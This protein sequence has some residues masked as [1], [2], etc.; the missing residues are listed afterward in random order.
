MLHK[1]VGPVHLPGAKSPKRNGTLRAR[2]DVGA[3]PARVGATPPAAAALSAGL[4]VA[5]RV[6]CLSCRCC[7]D[8]SALVDFGGAAGASLA[9]LFLFSLSLAGFGLVWV[10]TADLLVS[11]DA[12]LS[13]GTAS[14]A[15]MTR[16]STAWDAV[17]MLV[18]HAGVLLVRTAAIDESG[19][20]LQ[21]GVVPL[22][23]S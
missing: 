11:V 18:F 17:F 23:C 2:R 19:F 9:F 8:D 15:G 1:R 16:S 10:E 14:L 6:V 21:D 7:W 3:P 13:F 22:V 12:C 4:L 5:V 20:R